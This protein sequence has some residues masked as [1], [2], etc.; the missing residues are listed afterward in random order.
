MESQ[1]LGAAREIPSLSVASLHGEIR[2]EVRDAA[3]WAKKLE[4]RPAG[5]KAPCYRGLAAVLEAACL[6]LRRG[7]LAMT[8]VDQPL[9]GH[10]CR[11]PQNE[12]LDSP[13][14]C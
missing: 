5:T 2:R 14:P 12:T 13:A 11:K 7:S 8:G 9:S 1:I 3:T 4:N 6:A 10:P